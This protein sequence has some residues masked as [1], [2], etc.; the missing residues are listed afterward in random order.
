MNAPEGSSAVIVAVVVPAVVALKLWVIAPLSVTV[1]VKVSV[2]STGGGVGPKVGPLSQAVPTRAKVSSAARDRNTTV[3]RRIFSPKIGRGRTF[4]LYL[5]RRQSQ[6][7]S[8][9]LID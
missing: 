1:P 2:T 7:L 4:L 3:D 5:Q 6:G 8:N 9:L